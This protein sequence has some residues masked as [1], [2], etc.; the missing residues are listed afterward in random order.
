[1]PLPQRKGRRPRAKA[2]LSRGM[3]EL[4]GRLRAAAQ[5]ARSPAHSPYPSW[6]FPSRSGASV[7][8]ELPPCP[9]G[10]TASRTPERPL[11]HSS[12]RFALT[13]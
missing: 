1:M 3:Q 12:P 10:V 13:A 8:R 11:H 6:E 4:G 2:T 5:R 7:L 9:R